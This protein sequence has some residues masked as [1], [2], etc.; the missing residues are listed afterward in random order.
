MSKNHL[1]ASLLLALSSLAG[2]STTK[3]LGAA[4]AAVTRFHEQLD[5]ADFSAIYTEADQR[6]RDSSPQPEFLT[7][8][9]AV[10]AKLGKVTDATRQ[11]FFVNFTTS[12]KR[13]RLTYATKF[14]AGDAQEEFVWA[15]NGNDFALLGYHINSMALVTK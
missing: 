2:C 13:V 8:M 12:G 14:A 1:L 3:D 15:K 11:G 9:N 5:K 10:H 4:S 7:F 6:F